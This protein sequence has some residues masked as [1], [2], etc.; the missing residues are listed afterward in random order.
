MGMYACMQT[1]AAIGSAIAA[2][3]AVWVA[4]SAF[5]FQKNAL[6]K[7]TSVELMQQ[8]MQQ[9][10]S[11]KSLAGKTALGMAD[12]EFL[13]LGQRIVDAREGIRALESMLSPHSA[14]SLTELRDA[15]DGMKEEDFHAPADG[16]PRHRVVQRLDS[17]VSALQRIHR[18][19]MR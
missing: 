6:L 7:K 9:L 19:E 16:R 10:F 8:L 11:L 1:I 5:A 17:A 3:A 18:M 4:R 13:G 12:D 15:L 14:T 2:V